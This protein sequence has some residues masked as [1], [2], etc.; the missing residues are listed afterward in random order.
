MAD[1]KIIISS[2]SL[3]VPVNGQASFKVKLSARPEDRRAEVKIKRISGNENIRIISGREIE[4]SRTN[5]SQWQTVTLTAGDDDHDGGGRATFKLYGEDVDAATLT[6]IAVDD[7]SGA[8]SAGAQV[9]TSVGSVQVP[10][11]GQAS[12]NVKLSAPPRDERVEIKVRRVAGDESIRV[13]SGDEM[14]FSRRSYNQWRTVTLAAA[15][16]R[17]SRNGQATFKIYGEHVGAATLTATEVD[18]DITAPAYQIVIDRD[19]LNV[20]EGGTAVLHVSLSADPGR[21]VSVSIGHDGGDSSL[22]VVSGLTYYF[23]ATNWNAQQPIT[24][25]AAEDSDAA[26]GQATFALSALDAQ[27][28]YITAIAIDNDGAAPSGRV[29]IDPVSRIE[30]HLRVEV[31]V[32]NGQVAKAWSSATLFRGVETILTGRDPLDAPLITQRLCGVCT[33][34]HNLASVRAIEDAAKLEITDN[35]R[36]IR[37]LLLGA[38]FLHDHIVH[39]FHL[40]GLD[41]VDITSALQADPSA[42]ANLASDVSP[43]ADPIDF[44]EVKS[45]LQGLVDTGNLGPFANAYWGHSAYILSPEK[46]LLVTAHYLEALQKQ[47]VAAKMMAI[48]GG[49]NPHPQSTVVGGVTCGGELTVDRLNRFRAYLEETR[50]FVNTVY[51]PDLKV[52]AASYPDWAK[53]G[54]FTNFMACG[55]FPLGPNVPADLFMPRGLIFNGDFLDVQGL[56]P[57][58]ISEHVAR[59][60]YVGDTDRHPESGETQPNYTGMDVNDR[61]SWLKAPRHAGE[62][63]EVGPLARVLV[64]YGLGREEFVGP[65]E[66]FLYETGLNEANLL[67]TLGRTAARGIETAIIGDAMVGWLDQ[68]E[69]NLAVGNK[70]IFQQYTLGA[71]SAGTGFLEAP[72]GALGH[73]IRMR[74]SSIDNYQMVVPTTWNLGPR[75]ADGIPGPLEQALVGVPVADPANPLEVIRVIHSFD[76]CIACGVHVIDT[77]RHQTYTVSRL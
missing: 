56:D 50:K 22:S 54:T 44:S 73:W 13:L 39:F 65:V 72:R 9:V 3:Q 75:C 1:P 40:H 76:P 28:V 58:L 55:E 77:D 23:D 35:A 49:K 64:G 30:G 19:T 12:F 43:D 36:I 5:Y 41:W 33:Y 4:F 68:L 27:T 46:N 25:A 67:S 57:A 59:S 74:N 69:N 60:W 71:G 7:D 2:G 6:A 61:Y 18:N 66:N 20:M 51:L 16:D 11:G 53:V 63:M 17:D 31:E 8:P 48:L 70:Q 52:I 34:V 47:V 26:D 37:N 14:T 29:V 32:A 15:E 38:Q 24:V 10:E 45:R 21:I 42:T 62:A